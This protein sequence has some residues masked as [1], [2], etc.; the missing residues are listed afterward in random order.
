MTQLLWRH[1]PERPYIRPDNRNIWT[2]I[3]RLSNAIVGQ[4]D[5]GQIA[6]IGQH[7][8]GR[9][10]VSVDDA[11]TMRIGESISQSDAD[12]EYVTDH[13]LAAFLSKKAFKR[14]TAQI[15]HSYGLVLGFFV[16]IV[17]L[18]DMTMVKLALE[19]RPLPETLSEQDIIRATFW[20]P[21]FYR[22]ISPEYLMSGPRD[23]PHCTQTDLLAD[24][25]IAYK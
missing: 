16:I 22:D 19:Y 13:K 14:T 3:R 10:D 23:H 20:K 1:I 4:S 12:G 11:Q 15:L 17:D 21:K 9:F 24:L 5:R 25:V 8:I 2:S 6:G 18:S 7:D